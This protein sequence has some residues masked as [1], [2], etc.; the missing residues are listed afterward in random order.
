M[1]GVLVRG[2]ARIDRSLTTHVMTRHLNLEQRP[3]RAHTELETQPVAVI[4]LFPVRRTW[5][6][7]WA[8]HHSSIQ[9]N[10]VFLLRGRKKKGTTSNLNKAGCF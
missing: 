1:A 5:Q 8:D 9:D 10:A 6:S 7:R 3:I 4:E 2:S